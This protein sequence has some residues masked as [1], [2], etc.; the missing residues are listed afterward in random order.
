MR[1]VRAERVVRVRHVPFVRR[2]VGRGQSE[3]SRRSSDFSASVILR[4][5]ARN[6]TRSGRR[7]AGRGQGHRRRG[8]S[9]FFKNGR[10]N[11]V[12]GLTD[13]C[14]LRRSGSDFP[15][16]LDKLIASLITIRCRFNRSHAHF[17]P[18]ITRS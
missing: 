13:R 2:A 9:D 4:R 5:I 11:F 6:R 17:S 15:A 8:H 3:Q 1:V 14:S 12:V 7:R 18:V 10:K 16:R